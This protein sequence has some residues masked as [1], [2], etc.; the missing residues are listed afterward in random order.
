MGYLRNPL[1]HKALR[2]KASR[3]LAWT[4]EIGKEKIMA[5]SKLVAEARRLALEAKL[6]AEAAELEAGQAESDSED[7][8]EFIAPEDKWTGELSPGLKDAVIRDKPE[9]VLDKGGNPQIVWPLLVEGKRKAAFYSSLKPDAL[10]VLCTA[11]E[12]IGIPY[13]RKGQKVSF[14]PVAAISLQCKVLVERTEYKGKT[15]NKIT[16]LY[17]KDY[18]QTAKQAVE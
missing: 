1:K 14:D 12:S 16:R 9:M 11:L 18:G 10:W 4:L 7:T 6:A 13:T 15:R 17:G 8:I 3:V 2:T 5:D